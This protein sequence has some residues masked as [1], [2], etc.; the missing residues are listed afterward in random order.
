MTPQPSR[1]ETPGRVSQGFTLLELLVIIAIVGILAGFATLAIPKLTASA[2]AR[3]AQAL[4]ATLLKARRQAM[5][6]GQLIGVRITHGGYAVHRFDSG[7]WRPAEA[8]VAIRPEHRLTLRQQAPQR[9]DPAP[10][11]RNGPTPLP[12]STSPQLLFFPSG[13]FSGPQWLALTATPSGDEPD[14]H[15]PAA[16]LAI[17]AL[18]RIRRDPTPP[19]APSS[20]S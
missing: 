11:A 12:P 18:G 17:D 15:R 1:P 20:P 9:F 6:S 7:A 19:P 14:A 16:A 2:L 3:D 5:L 8:T 13:T 10:L 4:E